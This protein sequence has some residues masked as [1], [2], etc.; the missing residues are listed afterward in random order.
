MLNHD[1]H[2]AQKVAEKVE[3]LLGLQATTGTVSKWLFGQAAQTLLF[4]EEM[5]RRLAENNR[6]ATLELAEKML[7]AHDRGYWEAT[8]EDLEKLK[9]IILDMETWLE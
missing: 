3:Y 4:D 2:G 6:Y 7:E 1:F 5:R 9:T 8:P